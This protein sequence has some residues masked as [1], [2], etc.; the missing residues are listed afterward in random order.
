[1]K[2]GDA[3]DDRDAL[4]AAAEGKYEDALIAANSAPIG[5]PRFL[6]AMADVSAARHEL[7]DLYAGR[8]QPH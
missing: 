4:R 1:V 5:T 2:T 8:A 3:R 6:D 7:R